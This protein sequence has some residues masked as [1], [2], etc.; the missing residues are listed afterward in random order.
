MTLTVL[1][2]VTGFIIAQSGANCRAM[3]VNVNLPEAR[4][5]MSSL[6]NIVDDLGRGFGPFFVSLMIAGLGRE[7]AFVITPFFW[8][9]CA[10]VFFLIGR[11]LPR[12][13]AAMDAIL[14]ARAGGTTGKA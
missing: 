9:P 1:S 2:L 14:R 11:S 6:Y 4:G 12:D 8:V 10:L 5:S 7:T 3:L 13:V